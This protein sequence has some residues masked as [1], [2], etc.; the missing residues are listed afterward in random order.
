VATLLG[1]T[2]CAAPLVSLDR[3]PREYV[4]TDYPA[5]LERWTRTESL[6]LFD[7]L[8]RALTVTATFESWD[9]RS[10]F[11]IRYAQDYRLTIPQRQ[12]LLRERLAATDEHH[13]FYLALYGEEDR[14]NDLSRPD[15]AWIVR[16]IDST[17]GEV[18]PSAIEAVTRPGV[19]EQRFY[20]YSTVW[21]RA[22]R[23][24]F[25][26]QQA[27]GRPSIARGAE[28]FG[29]RFAGPWGNTDLNWR[30]APTR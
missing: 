20:P 29:L 10:A 26:T 30:L 14:Q 16:L 1:G 11:V 25:P 8:T 13:E 6:F 23:V 19:L 27:D 17:G 12:E 28:W 2:G 9:F 15:S 7:E 3:G 24:R 4:A 5:V 18:A 21:R 22:F